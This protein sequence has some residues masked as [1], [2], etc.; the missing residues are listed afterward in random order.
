MAR[1][2][3]QMNVFVGRFPVADAR[4][5]DDDR[6]HDAAAGGGPA[7]GIRGDPPPA[8]YGPAPCSR[9]PCHAGAAGNGRWRSRVKPKNPPRSASP[10]PAKRGRSRARPTSAPRQSSLR[11]SSAMH[12]GFSADVGCGR[13]S[14]H[15]RLPANGPTRRNLRSIRSGAWPRTTSIAVHRCPRRG[16]RVGAG[17]SASRPTSCSSA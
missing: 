1:V 11:S 16:L 10:K 12:V 13:P 8:R 3:P 15:R 2:A 17:R 4:R 6:H 5:A 14:V 9:A 7:A